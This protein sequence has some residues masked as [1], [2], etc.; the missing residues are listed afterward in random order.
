[1]IKD[2]V[3]DR[4]GFALFVFVAM[5]AGLSAW[6]TLS[7]LGWLYVFHNLLLAWLYFRREPARKYDRIGLWLGM[8]A[9]LL[10]TTVNN[11]PS[12]WYLLIPGLAGYAL[13]LWSLTVLGKRFGISPADRGLTSCG[14][15]RLIRHPMYFGELMYR[16]AILFNSRSL[17][18]DWVLLLG[19][20]ANWETPGL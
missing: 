14:P 13:I 10:P 19:R 18:V 2:S 3:R 5:I 16:A 9:V 11:G 6:K 1:M 7:L 4:L 17:I 20:Y 12:P 15:Y 8:I